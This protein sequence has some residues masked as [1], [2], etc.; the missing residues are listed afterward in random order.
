[1]RLFIFV[2]LFSITQLLAYEIT[3]APYMTQAKYKNSSKDSSSTNGLYTKYKAKN[4]AIALSYEQTSLDYNTTDEELNQKD[5][6]LS[7][8]QR[9]SNNYNLKTAYHQISSSSDNN[10]SADIYFLGLEYYKKNRFSVGAD[11]AYSAYDTKNTYQIRTF[12]GISFGD[13]KS[14]MGKF[15]IKT[16]A[17]MIYPQSEDTNNTLDSYYPSIGITIKQYK[18]D[19]VN[20]INGWMGERIYSVED[21]GFTVY[22]L[23]EL[24]SSGLYISSRYAITKT[25]GL[26]FSYTNE[27]FEDLDLNIDDSMQKYFVSFDY[28]LR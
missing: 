24:H 1:M 2:L 14:K 7:Y 3:L 11:F 13:Y 17:R 27:S 23:N 18:G 22:N 16:D 26:Q 28:T 15:L 9:I 6:T 4:Y 19:F 25:L 8:T 12:A 5:I 21:N 20:T 10:I